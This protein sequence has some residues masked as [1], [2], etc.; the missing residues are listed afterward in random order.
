METRYVKSKSTL[1]LNLLHKLFIFS[2][3]YNNTRQSAL[4]VCRLMCFPP[5]GHHETTHFIKLTL[6]VARWKHAAK[7]NCLNQ[8]GSRQDGINNE[9][10]S[11][12]LLPPAPFPG[13]AGNAAVSCI[14]ISQAPVG[15]SQMC[16][17]HGVSIQS[18]GPD[19]WQL[20]AHSGDAS[21]VEVDLIC[22][23]PN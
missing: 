1:P 15:Q 3:S 10:R 9:N 5:S 16:A 23:H 22:P 12:P 13:K 14:L 6:L 2:E 11:P 8:I 18:H 19:V 4:I 17:L 20:P 21:G 7:H